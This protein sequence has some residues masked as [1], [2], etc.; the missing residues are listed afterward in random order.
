VTLATD[1]NHEASEAVLE[2]GAK[3]KGRSILAIAGTVFAGAL[4]GA[5]AVTEAASFTITS[6]VVT[7]VQGANTV[8]WCDTGSGCQNQIWTLPA[9]GVTITDGQS[10][11]FTQTGVGGL[12][13]DFNFDTSDTFGR[14]TAGAPVEIACSA[15]NPCTVAVAINGATQVA[16]AN[17]ILNNFNLDNSLQSHNEARDY[18][19][20][21]GPFGPFGPAAWTLSLGYADNAHMSGS[22]ACADTNADCLPAP[23][24]L[25]GATN[26]ALFF[27]KGGGV[28]SGSSCTV[29]G[30]CYDAGAIRISVPVVPEPASLLLLGGGLIFG[31]GMARRKSRV[32]KQSTSESV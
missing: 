24:A 14:N 12:G 22:P 2:K 17:G 31:G 18:N 8:V 13:G 19:Q 11:V 5:P 21:Q 20:G 32:R 25:L 28:V 1:G 26:A 16:A 3:M 10:A 6:I 4:F 30:T 23:G 27:G 7:E 15:A 9:G 29:A